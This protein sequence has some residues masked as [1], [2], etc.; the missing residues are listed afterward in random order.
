[1]IGWQSVSSWFSHTQKASTLVE[2]FLGKAAGVVDIL[3]LR[4][5][6]SLCES[7]TTRL[8]EGIKLYPLTAGKGRACHECS[9]MC[10]TRRITPLPSVSDLADRH[11]PSLLTN[12]GHVQVKQ[13]N[14]RIGKSF[15]QILYSKFWGKYA[16]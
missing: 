8:N 11:L 12:T 1:M 10:V 14:R 9:A 3:H 15:I 5:P 7:I 2:A 16:G 4:F 6:T 13:V